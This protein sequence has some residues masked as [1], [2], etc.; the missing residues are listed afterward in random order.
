MIGVGVCPCVFLMPLVLLSHLMYGGD[1]FFFFFSFFWVLV[2]DGAS[3]VL[4]L[5]LA[6]GSS[7]G[8]RWGLSTFTYSG[9]ISVIFLG[10]LVQS[11]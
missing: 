3:V 5:V 7:K 6:C 9:S 4:L 10:V 2:S 1:L 8:E 11:V